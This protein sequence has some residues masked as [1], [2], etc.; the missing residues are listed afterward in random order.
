MSAGIKTSQNYFRCRKQ[1]P[2]LIPEV[3]YLTLTSGVSFC[4]SLTH[5]VSMN[6]AK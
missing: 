4:V 6:A 3:T 5:H 2:L 1:Q